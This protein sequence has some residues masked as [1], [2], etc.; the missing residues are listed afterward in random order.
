VILSISTPVNAA[1]SAED[2]IKYRNL[3]MESMAAHYGAL[4]LILFDKVDVTGTS[5]NHADALANASAE[6]D[7]L[8]PKISRDGETDAL[9]A[10]WKNSGA[11][12]KTVKKAQAAT[13][14]LQAAIASGDRK[15]TLSAAAAVGKSCKGCHELYRAEHEHDDSD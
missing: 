2:A 7:Q 12:G 8:F 15:T 6:L 5:Q 11:F 14:D 4:I 1:S 13:T 10:I 3:V 9:P